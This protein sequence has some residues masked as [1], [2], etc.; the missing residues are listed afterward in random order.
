VTLAR[1]RDQHPDSMTRMGVNHT[2]KD[3]KKH[4]GLFFASDAER[5]AYRDEEMAGISW[6]NP[7][8]RVSREALLKAM[9]EVETLA[10]WLEP[11][12]L[13]LRYRR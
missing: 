11:Q 2:P 7:S 9:D 4:P 6:M 12:I 5:K 10:E 1:N 3:R 13:K 8:V